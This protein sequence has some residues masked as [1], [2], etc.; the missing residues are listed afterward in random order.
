M[1]S[2][3]DQNLAAIGLKQGTVDLFVT[4]RDESVRRLAEFVRVLAPL[5]SLHAYPGL[6][7]Y[8]A[9][10]F[11]RK[12]ASPHSDLDLFF[13]SASAADLSIGRER[14]L[15]TIPVMADIIRVSSELGYPKPSND[16]EYLRVTDVSDVLEHMGG[17]QDDYKNHFTTRMLLLLESEPVFGVADYEAAVSAIVDA[18]LRDYEDHA[19]EFRPTFLVND[20][21]RFWK[22]LCLNYEH[23]R[24]QDGEA[25]KIKQKIRNFKLGFSRL[26]T[27]FSAIS[28]FSSYNSIEKSDMLH[29]FSLSPVERLLFLSGRIPHASL[30][31]AEA[32]ELYAWFLE[33]TARG[34]GEL[35]VYFSSKENRTEAFGRARQFG[36]KIFAILAV[37]AGK[38]HTMRYLVV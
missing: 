22:T 3:L 34:Q 26:M 29:I 10:S 32:L 16:G 23:R 12:E 25:R 4:R 17:A 8:A 28:C 15:L 38:K 37:V 19:A 11:A 35:E 9:G 31:I 24:N 18:Y 14:R 13:L 2:G 7:I 27:C 33:V 20:I 30:K 21:L 6:A 5:P 36:D 1:P